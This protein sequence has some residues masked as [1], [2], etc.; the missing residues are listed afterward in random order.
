M[1]QDLKSETHA[2]PH[3]QGDP[4]QVHRQEHA[5]IM[6]YGSGCALYLKSA[7]LR[8]KAHTQSPAASAQPPSRPDTI[9]AMSGAALL[10]GEGV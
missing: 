2:P 10:G 5:D 1:G 8:A 6:L 7:I 3:T 4:P 9:S